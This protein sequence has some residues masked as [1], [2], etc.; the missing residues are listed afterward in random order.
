MNIPTPAEVHKLAVEK[1]WYDDID[2]EDLSKLSPY[3]IP[4][5]I[6]LMHSELSEALEVYR[7]S[8]VLVGGDFNIPA[9]LMFTEELAD[10]VLRIFDLAGFLNLPLES[11]IATK[12]KTNKTRPHRHGG[13]IV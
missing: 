2:R 3:F 6:S 4:T 8:T 11:C 10:A 13:K 12:H 5:Q 1:G 9:K 7:S